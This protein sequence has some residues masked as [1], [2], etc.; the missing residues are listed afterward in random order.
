M[1]ELPNST[2]LIVQGDDRREYHVRK[3]PSQAELAELNYGRMILTEHDLYC[4]RDDHLTHRA[5]AGQLGLDGIHV[6]RGES[7]IAADIE[8]VGVP[9]AF[10]WLY[11]PQDG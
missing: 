7:V 4:W 11:A 9:G 1:S 3:N 10:P 8:P 5:V 2:D 6:L